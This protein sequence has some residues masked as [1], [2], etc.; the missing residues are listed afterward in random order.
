MD[1]AAYDLHSVAQKLLVRHLET[2]LAGHVG[3]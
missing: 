2:K 1:V 3:R